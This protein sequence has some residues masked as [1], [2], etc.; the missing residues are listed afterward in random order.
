MSIMSKRFERQRKDH[1][2]YALNKSAIGRAISIVVIVVIIGV[3]L[4]GY[5]LGLSNQGTKVTTTTIPPVTTTTT[6]TIL[7]TACLPPTCSDTTTTSTGIVTSSSQSF[8]A[9][10]SI[11]SIMIAN[12]TIGEFRSRIGVNPATNTVYIPY[13]NGKNSSIAVVNGTTNKV[14]ATIPNLL[15]SDTFLLVN[16][17]TNMLYIGNVV[18]NDSTN[19]VSTA[20]NA[21]LTFVAL[22]QSANLLFAISENTSSDRL[23]SQLYEINGTTNRV[24]ESQSAI[25]EAQ[26]GGGA[27]GEVALDST[28]HTIYLSVCTTGFECY[29]TYVYAMNEYNMSVEARIPINQFVVFAIVVDQ[30]TNM[31]YATASQNLLLVING[32]TNQIVDS[33][34]ISAYAN[35]LRNM[36]IDPSLGELFITGSPVCQGALPDCGIDTLY[37]VST[38]N[39]G[40]LT[41]FSTG[42]NTG[43]EP[44]YLTFNPANNETYMS[45]SYSNY[46]LAVKVPHYQVSILLP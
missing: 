38:Q 35:Q 44:I 32:T 4:A 9:D 27:V 17:K 3:A 12:M 8:N 28:T 34:P 18:I 29:P 21:N 39:Y 23:S 25:G 19:K 1:S 13:Y 37:V 45:F 24:I 31:V 6:Q 2:N 33:V 46:V 20:F 26:I 10:N 15:I 5:S 42:N 22:D 11:S 40:L 36:E 41:F 16:S 7:T 30:L 43:S 14:V